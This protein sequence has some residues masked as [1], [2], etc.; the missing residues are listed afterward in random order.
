MKAEHDKAWAAAE[1]PRIRPN[2]LDSLYRY[3]EDG[4]PTGDF[5]RAVLSNDLKE[6]FGRADE[7]NRETLFDI[8][9]FLYNEAPA[10]CWGSPDLVKAWLEKETAERV[11]V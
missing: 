4:C 11:V 3:I 2:M 10:P 9:S 8:V 1:Y 5:L 7:Q 6:S